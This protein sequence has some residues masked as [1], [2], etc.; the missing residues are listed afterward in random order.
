[1]RYVHKVHI[2]PS[3]NQQEAFDFWI[4]RCKVLY[5]T[6]LEHRIEHWRKSGRGIS[7]YEQKKELPL[8]KELDAS[9][10][11]VPN[12]SLTECLLRL[13]K[14]FKAFF[15]QPSVGFPKFK[16]NSNYSSLYFVKTDINIKNDVVYLPKLKSGIKLLELVDHNYTSVVLK[17]DGEKYYLVF[18]YDDGRE[19]I[20]NKERDLLRKSRGIDLGL[21][22]LLTDTE[23]YY[24]KRFS[25][26][27]IKSYTNR[28]C[29]LNQS[30]A[31]CK[32]G[33]KRRKKVRTQLTKAHRRLKNTRDDYQKKEI[34][35]YIKG[36]KEQGV[37]LLALGNIEV[38]KIVVR[39]DKPSKRSLRRSF[40][41]SGLGT[42]KNLLSVKAERNGIRVYKIGEEYTSQACSCCGHIKADLKLSDRVYSCTNCK[43]VIDRDLNGS[44]NIQAAWQGQFRPW[45]L[46]SQGTGKY[47]V[48][49]RSKTY[50]GV[51]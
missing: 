46:D 47:F 31:K 8:I 37:E 6:A 15:K 39:N 4:R 32:K 26:K 19:L 5:N 27:L 30:L 21:K 44:L 33:S 51:F 25:T 24:I 42:F 9:W 34:F 35:T 43:K 38:K 49:D 14:A 10:K 22:T 1:M 18:N 40:A 17:K 36:L 45:C 3:I 13:D 48:L 50:L 29:E 41:Q 20:Y 12:K 28:I 23:N 11:D 2:K 16:S 7:Y